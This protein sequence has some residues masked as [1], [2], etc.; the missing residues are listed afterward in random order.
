MQKIH[1]PHTKHTTT[2]TVSW[3]K[4]SKCV[5]IAKD[6]IRHTK[7]HCRQNLGK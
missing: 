7:T 4:D 6:K 2:Q 5:G 3:Q 1:V